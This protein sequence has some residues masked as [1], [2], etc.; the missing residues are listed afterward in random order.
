MAEIEVRIDGRFHQV[1]PTNRGGGN[2]HITC[3]DCELPRPKRMR[4][5]SGTNCAIARE[6]CAA[7]EHHVTL[8][9]KSE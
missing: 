6:D 5:V 2:C 8:I 7:I 1:T 9:R 4:K 3:T